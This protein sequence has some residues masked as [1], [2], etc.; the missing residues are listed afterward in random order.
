M[1]GKRKTGEGMVLP[2]THRGV[3]FPGSVLRSRYGVG[4]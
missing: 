1:S 3:D 4:L 2:Y